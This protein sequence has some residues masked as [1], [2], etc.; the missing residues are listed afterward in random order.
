MNRPLLKQSGLRAGGTFCLPRD[1][2]LAD[3]NDHEAT[4]PRRMDTVELGP[5]AS[6]F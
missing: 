3:E 2:R 4:V 5:H 1:T 6:R